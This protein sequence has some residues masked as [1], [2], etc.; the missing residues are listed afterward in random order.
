MCVSQR[1][2]FF[3]TFTS[4]GFLENTAFGNWI[5]FRPQV[6]VG[7]K[8]PTQLGPLERANLN[9]WTEVLSSSPV[10]PEDGNRCS[11]RNVVFSRIPGD[12]KSPKTL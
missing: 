2:I 10:S 6:K 3:F 8:T 1:I 12:G 9:H 4:S 7:K 5:C 11:F